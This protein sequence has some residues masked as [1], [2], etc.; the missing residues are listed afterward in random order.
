MIQRVLFLALFLV[1][2]VAC[3]RAC[4]P[5]EVVTEVVQVVVTA[6]PEV[7][8]T[9]PATPVPTSVTPV[10]LPTRL[11]E[12]SV[13]AVTPEPTVDPCIDNGVWE[14]GDM[15]DENCP[16]STVNVMFHSYV[17]EVEIG[18]WSDAETYVI[19]TQVELHDDLQVSRFR[20]LSIKIHV[21]NA[22]SDNDIPPMDFGPDKQ[23]WLFD[24]TFGELPYVPEGSERWVASVFDSQVI[25]VFLLDE[26]LY[27]TV[28]NGEVIWLSPEVTGYER[29]GA[30]IVLEFVSCGNG[31][32]SCFGMHGY[33]YNEEGHMACSD[34]RFEEGYFENRMIA[35]ASNPP[36]YTTLV[37]SKQ[38]SLEWLRSGQVFVGIDYVEAS[39]ISG[40]EFLP[41]R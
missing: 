5:P 22:I 7:T 24:V 37:H 9:S 30:T 34:H 29:A 33:T 8:P 39:S 21:D 4:P 10:V 26:P 32:S 20:N 18:H 28:V 2:C 19:S 15:I 11:S 1:A 6:T 31:N 12:Q 17:P 3:S 25:A 35:S 23:R 36:C 41:I 14:P 16:I 13:P 40:V 38:D 27:F